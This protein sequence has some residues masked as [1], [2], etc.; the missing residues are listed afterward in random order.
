MPRFANIDNTGIVDGFLR[1]YGEYLEERYSD[2]DMEI[3]FIDVDKGDDNQYHDI[4]ARI[5]NTIFIS[6]NECG[7]IGLTDVEI[8]AAIAHEIGHIIFRADAFQADSENRADQLAA[9]LGLGNQMISVIEKIIMSR[10]YP[11][12]T[13]QL[14]QRIQFLSHIA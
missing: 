6:M 14:V 2:R 3:S 10:R 11:R 9:E 8:F 13:T 4:M 7:K 1:M 5:N 12:L